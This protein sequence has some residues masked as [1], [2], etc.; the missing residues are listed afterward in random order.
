MLSPAVLVCG[1]LA[2]FSVSPAYTLDNLAKLGGGTSSAAWK[3]DRQAAAEINEEIV[4]RGR[5]ANGVVVYYFVPGALL[6]A[7]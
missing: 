7:V 1:G 2:F 5:D 4:F 6:G 3:K